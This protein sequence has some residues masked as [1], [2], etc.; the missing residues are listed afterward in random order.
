M[1]SNCGL[2]FNN[3]ADDNYNNIINNVKLGDKTSTLTALYTNDSELFSSTFI[4]ALS[5]F[6]NMT[7]FTLFDLFTDCEA[8]FTNNTMKQMAQ[9]SDDQFK[10]VYMQRFLV[11]IDAV[12][13]FKAYNFKFNFN[14]LL[15]LRSI[16]QKPIKTST[17]RVAATLKI[18][19]NFKGAS[20]SIPQNTDALTI[21]VRNENDLS[22]FRDETSE[23]EYSSILATRRS[24]RLPDDAIM[25]TLKAMVL[26]EAARLDKEAA[27][28][29]T[30]APD[31]KQ[32]IS[33]FQ[34]SNYC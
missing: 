29:I 18:T 20:P 23:I 27:I 11:Y 12:R 4:D 30:T 22:D 21:I 8:I 13:V 7:R 1:T 5:S 25:L 26:M 17:T 28:N 16:L 32:T 14:D 3:K 19:N 33:T 24:F 15:C 9:A 10:E 31:I 34:L 2:Y 6:A